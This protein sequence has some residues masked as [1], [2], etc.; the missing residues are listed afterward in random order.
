M[1][2][3]KSQ[4]HIEMILSFALF[5]GA[6]ITLFVFINPLSKPQ[7][8]DY[9]IDNV[10]RLFIKEISSNVGKISVFLEDSSTCY[11]LPS[12]YGNNFIEVQ[13]NEDSKRYNIYFSKDFNY[14][15]ISCSSKPI[16]NYNLGVYLEENMLIYEKIIDLKT[17]YKSD[18]PSLKTLLGINN[19]FSWN[20]KD[21][22]GNEISEISVSK[23]IPAV[24]VEAKEFPVRI[25]DKK[26]KIY[27]LILNIKE[28]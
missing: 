16:G 11:N 1:T 10:Q 28:W 26:G 14:G 12:E 2:N 15:I 7:E 6:I 19:E 20:F 5:I 22:N 25:I 24:K 17:K 18:Y 27:E 13:N 21:F 9:T 8:K 23:N 3:I 4:A